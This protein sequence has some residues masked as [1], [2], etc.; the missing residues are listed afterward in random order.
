MMCWSIT[1]TVTTTLDSPPATNPANLFNTSSGSQAWNKDLRVAFDHNLVRNATNLRDAEF[2][3][4]KFS[5]VV[6]SFNTFENVDGYLQQRQGG[7]WEVRSNWFEKMGSAAP[8]KCFDDF[9]AG[10][11]SGAGRALVIGN[12]LVG[13]L[14]MEIPS[15]DTNAGGQPNEKGNY[16]PSRQGRYIGNIVGGQIRVSSAGGEFDILHPAGNNLWDNEVG[17]GG[18]QNEF[19]DN[20]VEANSTGTTFNADDEAYTPAGVVLAA[21]GAR[22]KIPVPTGNPAT[23]QVGTRAPDPL[24]PGGPQS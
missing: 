8:L 19:G 15:G 4:C 6:F 24:C 21:G 10:T 18:V 14:H 7:G 5:G 23:D 3:T 16:H 11:K 20:L 2:V 1:T 22:E 17:G 9:V 13:N 12:R